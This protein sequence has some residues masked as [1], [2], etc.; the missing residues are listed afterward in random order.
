M[1]SFHRKKL[2][3]FMFSLFAFFKDLA[4]AT[5]DP[6]DMKEFDS[7]WNPERAEHY[8]QLYSELE[9][10]NFLTAVEEAE[11]NFDLTSTEPP[12]RNREPEE[13]PHPLDCYL[14]ALNTTDLKTA[15]PSLLRSFR[16][17]LLSWAAYSDLPN[18]TVMA[19]KLGYDKVLP[20]NAEGYKIRGE[21]KV[22][23]AD[24][25]KARE[26]RSSKNLK[27][28]QVVDTNLYVVQGKDSA[29]VVFRGTENNAVKTDLKT[30]LM[31][32]PSRLGKL[33][34]VHQGF[35]AGTKL[36]WKPLMTAL[37]KL[38]PNLP[39]DVGGH[40][41]G[42]AH[43]QLMSAQILKKESPT[44][45][46]VKSVYE[47]GI[48]TPPV[49]LRS[50][51]LFGSPRVGNGTFKKNFEK[52]MQEGGAAGHPLEFLSFANDGDPVTVIPSLRYRHV[53][54]PVFF[55][56]GQ[57]FSGKT[58]SR[59]KAK[60]LL[61]YLTQA[62]HWLHNHSMQLYVTNIARELGFDTSSC[63]DLGPFRSKKTRKT[64]EKIPLE[65]IP[66]SRT[67]GANK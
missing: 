37:Q 20:L 66:S 33:G 7:P 41:L 2:V 62:R 12:V 29:A 24:S 46:K 30:D 31:I 4:H 10:S 38:P 57:M 67:H 14:Q 13:E 15:N 63:G 18:F 1:N 56:K 32:L 59:K 16:M 34:W 53:G 19:Q 28:T 36:A 48:E 27:S 25:L 60:T 58:A 5:P 55:K 3:V 21:R 49:Q 54:R 51:N 26:E 64:E 50:I 35:F 39:I 44:L 11:E 6:E 23:T 22:I 65:G 61:P 42:A 8:D 40:S 17:G 9:D 52:L 45:S 47:S 43:A